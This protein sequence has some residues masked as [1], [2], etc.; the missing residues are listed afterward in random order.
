MTLVPDLPFYIEALAGVFNG[1]NETAFG[2][3]SLQAPLVTGRLRTF[4]ELGN[5][6]AV[7]LGVSVASGQTPERLPSTIL[8]W[9]GRYKYRPDGWL[10]PLVTLTTEG[11]YSWRQ[12]NVDVDADGDGVAGVLDKREKDRFGWRSEERRVGKEGRSRWSPYH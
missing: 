4:L 1:D 10:H 5:E 3:T 6:H 2:R 7:Q 9:E 8:G 11:L 12:F